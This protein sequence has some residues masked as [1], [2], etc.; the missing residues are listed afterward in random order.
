MS[1]EQPRND[2][3]RVVGRLAEECMAYYS[4]MGD[5]NA[6]RFYLNLALPGLEVLRTKGRVEFVVANQAYWMA[7]A[8]IYSRCFAPGSRQ[9]YAKRAVVPDDLKAID[10]QVRNYRNNTAHPGR[11]PAGGTGMKVVLEDGRAH[12]QVHAG[13][14]R[15]VSGEERDG[16]ERLAATLEDQYRRLGDEARDLVQAVVNDLDHSHLHGLAARRVPLRV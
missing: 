14:E 13:V 3:V 5:M 11:L 1:L 2:T 12:V 6:V 9:P 8:V 7:A 10:G 4:L 15:P 16:L